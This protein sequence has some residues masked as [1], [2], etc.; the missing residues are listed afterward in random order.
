MLKP[1]K[2][3]YRKIDSGKPL[4]KNNKRKITS[5]AIEFFKL[6]KKLS[7]LKS[8]DRLLYENQDEYDF[9]VGL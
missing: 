2:E 6:S 5:D 4:D 9:K 3:E 1:K 7:H 8:V